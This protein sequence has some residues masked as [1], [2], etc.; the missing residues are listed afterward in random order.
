[1][2]H[3][4]EERINKAKANNYYCK[5][6]TDE[7]PV[8]LL[9]EL[10]NLSKESVVKVPI[11]KKGITSGQPLRCY[12]NANVIS[13]TFGGMPVYGWMISN[14]IK[15]G[16]RT[17]GVSKGTRFFDSGEVYSIIGHGV[18][19]T[20]EGKLVDVTG[21]NES[22][23]SDKEFRY[24]L[25]SNHL[26]KLN[27]KDKHTLHS[28]DF[29]NSPKAVKNLL[30]SNVGNFCK[31]VILAKCQMDGNALDYRKALD[32]EFRD[33]ALFEESIDWDQYVNK[34]IFPQGFPKMIW[35]EGLENVLKNKLKFDDETIKKVLSPQIAIV[36]E[37]FPK[38]M[39]NFKCNGHLIDVIKEASNLNK[40]IFEV[41]REVDW[42]YF[43]LKGDDMT[44]GRGKSVG[45]RE[46]SVC[47]ISTANGKTIY[48]ISPK[49]EVIASHTLPRNKKRRRKIEKIAKKVDLSVEEILTLNNEYLFPHPYLCK[50]ND[51]EP[52][53]I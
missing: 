48:E 1:M 34:I 32:L 24:F 10:K 30:E 45:M 40:N 21:T 22:E 11:R 13:Q 38:F 53:A 4:S 47:G 17:S 36:D 41:N 31:G 39:R 26:L 15:D 35:E 9:Q 49:S 16:V 8:E 52:I 43:F 18:W 42:E 3:I 28:F 5:K 37:S 27:G 20:P 23:D 6:V 25:P 50:K 46:S 14:C 19:M 7:L 33:N 29:T 12:W 2:F 44:G 51:F